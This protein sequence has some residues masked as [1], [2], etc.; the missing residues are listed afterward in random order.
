MLGG[1]ILVDGDAGNEIGLSMQQGVIAIGG[2]AGDMLGF[3]MTDGT[4]LIVGDSGIRA[5]AGMHGGTIAMLGPTPPP[6]LPS[7]RHDRTMQLESLVASLRDLRDRGFK[8]EESLL[9]A[10]VDVY[11]G[12]LVADGSGE[13]CL[14]H[15]AAA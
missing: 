1:T 15:I 5:G 13:I 10:E 7:F 6:M 4:I 2:A 11:V 9:P 3:N 14:R 8:F 12:D